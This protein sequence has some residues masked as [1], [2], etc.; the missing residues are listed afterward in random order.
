MVNVMIDDK[1][2]RKRH[3]AAHVMAA[4]VK[5]LF[6]DVKFDI[7]PPT[8]EGFY[9]DFDMDHRL[10]PEDLPKIEAEMKKLVAKRDPFVCEELPRD[11]AMRLLEQDRQPYKVERL[12]DIPGGE[13]ITFYKCGDF[14]DLCRGPH[15]DHT[16]DIGTFKLLSIAGSYYRGNE[17]NPMLQRIYG[18]AFSSPKELKAYLK[19]IEEAKKRD[20]R[21]I[22]T[23]L[24][25]FS[26]SEDIGSGL[27]LWHPKGGRI[28]NTIETFWREEHYKHGYEQLYTPHLGYSELWQTS[29][30]LDF[31]QEAMYSPISIDDRNYFMKPM[32]CPFHIKIYQSRSRSYRELPLRWAE[33]GTVYR[34]EKSGVLHGLLRVRGFTQDDAHIFCTH[35]QIE[36]EIIEV[37]RF[38]LN[39]WKAFGFSEIKAYLSTRPEKSVGGE[40][41]W[42]KATN[43]LEKAVKG[44][45]LECEVDPGGGAFYGPKIDLK[46]KDAIGREWQTTTIQFDFN[47]PE[48]FELYYIGEDGQKH[49][50]YMVHRAL[51]GSLER[52]FGI[53][54]EHY[55]G[56]FPTWLAPVQ[57]RILPIT[58]A[59]HGFSAQVKKDLVS[60]GL[61]VESD[62]KNE[63]LGSKIRRSRNERIPYMLIIGDREVENKEVSV[64]KRGEDG[65][66]GS[67]SIQQFIHHILDEIQHKC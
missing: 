10:I 36:E 38:S 9:Y 33:L 34:Y 7:G 35:D 63:G 41:L 61:R 22:G 3:S 18:T 48:R 59:H 67:M 19:R 39:I 54:T 50:P 46:I 13:K 21:R 51:L 23:D 55:A 62:T 64:R 26:I 49:R 30:H 11:K 60:R 6:D 1:L 45:N 17:N 32:N 65:V 58:D 52:F 12:Q 2:Y 28:R 66:L 14:V 5:N 40:D 44:A 47:L 20:H 27:I 15:V 4:A 31:Y 43:S 8:E 53:L 16:G 42:Q 37:L 29:G 56:A 24:E 57:V 25:L